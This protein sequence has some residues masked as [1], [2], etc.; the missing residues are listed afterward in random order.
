[1]AD[2]RKTTLRYTRRVFDRVWSQNSA[3]AVP[4]GTGGGTW[5]HNKGCVKAKQLRVERMVAGS[6][7]QELVHFAPDRVDMLYVNRGS[8]V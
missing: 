2:P 1:V 5:R 4:V 6:K 8:L 7:T 3:V